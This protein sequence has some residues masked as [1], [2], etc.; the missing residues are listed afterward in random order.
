MEWFWVVGAG[1]ILIPI[2]IVLFLNP[3]E[4]KKQELEEIEFARS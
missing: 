4:T 1:V 3:T 2:V